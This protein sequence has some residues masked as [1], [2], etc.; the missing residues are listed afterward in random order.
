MT[1]FDEKMAGLRARFVVRAGED[2]A[3]LE[4]ALAALDRVELKRLAHGLSGSAGIFGFPQITEEAQALEAALDSEA[5]DEE[6]RR[7]SGLLLR[8]LP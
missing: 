6:L 3:R 5:V 4:A 7:L 2:R 8:S 1:G